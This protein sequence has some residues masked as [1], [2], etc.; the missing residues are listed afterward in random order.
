MP[1]G[2]VA[3]IRLPRLQLTRTP[4]PTIGAVSVRSL[5]AVC[6]NTRRRKG[7]LQGIANDGR[8]PAVHI[9]NKLIAVL[10]CQALK[11][12]ESTTATSVSAPPRPCTR[13][14]AT[15]CPHCDIDAHGAGRQ[16]KRAA[17]REDG[18]VFSQHITA[19]INSPVAVVIKTIAKIR[20]LGERSN[21]TCARREGAI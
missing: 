4:Q 19:I 21:C 20:I 2:S 16:G 3:T 18:W 7:D 8:S 13:A 11:D 9:Y 10:D 6:A 17:L 1:T 5:A 12:T 14:G 15:R